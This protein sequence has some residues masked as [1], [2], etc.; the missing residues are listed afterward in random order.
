MRQRAPDPM[1][2]AP[3]QVGPLP[4][5]TAALRRG[6]RAPDHMARTCAG[7]GGRNTVHWQGN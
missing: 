5:L 1:G 2:I 7:S 6:R 4:A 3:R